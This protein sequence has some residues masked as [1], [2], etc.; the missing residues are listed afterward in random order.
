[1]QISLTKKDIIWGYF[2]QFFMLAS[3]ILVLPA[4]LRVL[5][6]NEVGMNYLMLTVSSLVA[7]F[8]FG[9]APQFGRNITYVFSGASELKKEGIDTNSPNGEINYHLLANMIQTARFIYRR[10]AFIVLLFM[11]TVGTLYIYK[12]TNGFSTVQHSFL[13]WILFSISTFFNVY[14]TYYASLLTGRGQIKEAQKAMVYSKIVYIVLTLIFLK[15]GTGLMGVVLANLIAPFVNRY[16]SYFYF[17][18]S[19]LKNKISDIVI[20]KKEKVD[21]FLI[22]WH[23]AKKLGLVFIGAYSINK[24][25]M[26]M[27]GLFLPLSQIGSYGLMTQLFG[28]VASVAGTFFSIHQPVF[29]SLR[30][31]RNNR[32][33]LQK[34]SLSMN[35]YYVL[36]FMGS[37]LI[38]FAGTFILGFIRS[39][40]VLPSIGIMIIYSIVL[41]LEG[42]HSNFATLIVT[43]NDIPFVKA[44]LVSGAAIAL[45]S[46]FSLAFTAW[47]I[48]GLVLVQGVVQLAY[49]NWK[50]PYYIFKEFNINLLSFLS[51]GISE[52]YKQLKVYLYGR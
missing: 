5:S 1:M 23:N 2:A 34:F 29:S 17:F 7:L 16:Y 28:I 27:A 22:I 42:N 24:L 20:S 40:T 47:G 45:G 50:W 31:E 38:I 49:N 33:L 48:L 25:S 13:I 35:I 3:G 18:T 52:S 32:R 44:S 46:Y 11:F 15:L 39:K 41:L 37:L 43:K 8:D 4:I 19:E 10:L 6:P 12:V 26:F 14:Y 30:I 36:F 51:L 21:L 9:F